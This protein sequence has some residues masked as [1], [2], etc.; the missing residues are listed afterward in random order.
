MRVHRASKTVE[1]RLFFQVLT[2]PAPP[3]L[4]PEREVIAVGA[5]I[6]GAANARARPVLTERI[7]NRVRERRRIKVDE[8]GRAL[9]VEGRIVA[10]HEHRPWP[11]REHG[12]K[13]S[14]SGVIEMV[15][16]FVQEQDIR[17]AKQQSSE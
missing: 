2:L 4:S 3:L 14:R 9:L 6:P 15:C 10:S 13:V 12:D 17:S 8:G 1:F 16:R 11:S 5:R 7:C